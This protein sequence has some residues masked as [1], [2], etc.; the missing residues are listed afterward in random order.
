[1]SNMIVQVRFI[2]GSNI[3]D[4]LIEAQDLA[5]KLNV[6]YVEFKFNGIDVSIAPHVDVDFSVK[7]YWNEC[8]KN[9]DKV[10]I[11]S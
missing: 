8:M 1:M 5:T 11:F 7:D 4:C 3:I 9:G 10:V 2:E 6:A